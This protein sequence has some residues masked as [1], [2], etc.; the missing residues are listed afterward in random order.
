MDT[1]SNSRPAERP[2]TADESVATLRQMTAEQLLYLGKRRVA[3][4]KGRPHDG[5]MIFLLYGA[6]GEPIT[7]ADDIEEV[8]DAANELG[9]SFIAVH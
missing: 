9:L 3:Y 6:D 5:G 2:D 4:L 1:Q 7:M 8:A